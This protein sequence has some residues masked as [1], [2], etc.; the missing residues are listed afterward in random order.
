LLTWSHGFAL[1]DPDAVYGEFY[2]CTAPRN[3]SHLC[4]AEVD[5]LFEKQ[6]QEVDPAKRKALVLEMERKAVPTASKIITQWNKTRNASWK[7]VKDYVRHPSSYNNIRYR[8]VW[9][10]K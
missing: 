8:D 2:N 1:D 3:W 9:L 6:S 4:T 10:D 5:A 7:F